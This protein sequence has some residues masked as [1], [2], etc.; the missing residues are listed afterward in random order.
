MEEIIINLVQ[1]KGVWTA[2]ET[3][4]PSVKTNGKHPYEALGRLMFFDGLQIKH[5]KSV[6]IDIRIKRDNK[7][8]GK[9]D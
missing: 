5:L 1:E 3:T 4:N 6:G 8:G 9:S 7:K 2:V